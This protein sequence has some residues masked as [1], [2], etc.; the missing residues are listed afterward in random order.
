M[1]KVVIFTLGA[2]IVLNSLYN[3]TEHEAHLH[4]EPCLPHNVS[5]KF[6]LV[7]SGSCMQSDYEVELEEMGLVTSSG[8]L[9]IDD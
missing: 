1:S 7:E 6:M 4:I 3:Y 2:K 5:R 8:S 9:F